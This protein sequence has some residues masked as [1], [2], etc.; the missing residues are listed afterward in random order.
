MKLTK[1]ELNV[2][3]AIGICCLELQK[4]DL[5]VVKEETGVTMP[6]LKR[7]RDDGVKRPGLLT[8]LAI[9]EHFNVKVSIKDLRKARLTV[10][11]G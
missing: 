11:G 8:F 9:A 4:A 3:E 1:S 10:V 7:W 6:T 2:L 5:K